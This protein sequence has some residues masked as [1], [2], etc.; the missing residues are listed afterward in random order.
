MRKYKKYLAESMAVVLAAGS[1]GAGA[2]INK[3]G[4]P[5][6]MAPA[7]ARVTASKPEHL[8]LSEADKKNLSK[9]ETVYVI[10][11][12]DG[13]TQDIIVSDWIKNAMSSA[14]IRDE[15]ELSNI[16]NV[17]GTESFL[18]TANA[19]GIWD[20]GGNDIYYQGSIEKELPVDMKITYS[21]NGSP[22]SPEELAG[23]S[24]H[25]TMRFTY[26]NN[27]KQKVLVKEEQQEMYVPFM[28]LTTMMLDNEKFHNVEVS[29]GKVIN[30][31]EHLMVAGYALPGLQ[32]NLE[33]DKE[34]LDIPEFVEVT[35]D[36]TDFE[37]AAT[38][39]MVTNSIFNEIDLD[40]T[41]SMDELS[42]DLDELQDAMG[43]L[44]DGSGELYDGISELY[45]KSG[46]LKD[47]SDKL[48]DGAA[49]LSDGAKSL[50]DGAGSLRTGANQLNEGLETLKKNNAA[51]NA[52]A[53]E[54]FEMLLDTA[55]TS[56]KQAG[57]TNVPE[58]TI[59]NYSKVLNQIA[60]SLSPD[61][62][63]ALAEQTARAQVRAQVEANRSAIASAVEQQ[64]K[65]QI[66]QQMFGDVAGISVNSQEETK[67]EETDTSL[68]EEGG[69][70]SADKTENS[71]GIEEGSQ[72]QGSIQDKAPAVSETGQDTA[73]DANQDTEQ[74]TDQNAAQVIANDKI[75][76][77]K[78]KASYTEEQK[79]Q[80][81][82]AAFEGDDMQRTFNAQVEQAINAQVE[83]AMASS[84]VQGQIN[85]AVAGASGGSAS[86]L[87]ALKASL[88]SYNQFYQ[89]LL[90]YMAG[91]AEASKGSRQL[92]EGSKELYDGAEKLYDGTKELRNGTNDLKDGSTKLIDG[93]LKLKDGGLELSDGVKEFDEEG[94]QK[95]T[96]VFEDD[97]EGLVDKMDA[98]KELSKEYRSFAGISDEMEGSVKFIYKTEGIE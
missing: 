37:L 24:G 76:L 40:D 70:L 50:R 63:R 88:D 79:Q 22:I 47:G 42:E 67:A 26:T 72:T 16:V 25:V 36:V 8:R 84:Q 4:S 18:Q 55:E 93:V 74:N 15:T 44:I 58:L 85:A 92:S 43:K 41:D 56:L 51:L 60:A 94:I 20:A 3:A 71:E 86:S 57:V 73:V 9:D 29:S 61:S 83:Q 78:A 87:A 33:V 80:I 30:D 11:G 21:L 10:A 90:T 2:W 91:V 27:Q 39:T 81:V 65:A 28:V 19:P 53:K 34:D 75:V 68:T 64:M 35:A 95:L 59:E 1:I 13:S 38:L 62:V 23:K 32:E 48:Y 52:G 14:S 12:A 89:G 96:E 77:V 7:A 97:V 45:D 69:D 46:D 98:M 17:K 66:Y 6:E 54:V 49:E 82:N 31:G 5:E